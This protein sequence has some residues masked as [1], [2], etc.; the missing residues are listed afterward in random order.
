[1]QYARPRCRDHEEL[2]HGG[3][4][5]AGGAEVEQPD[6]ATLAA[7]L[8]ARPV[9]PWVRLVAGS[10]DIDIVIIASPKL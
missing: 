6:V 3:G 9:L 1:M 7:T 2:L 5:V 4:H 8:L 10:L